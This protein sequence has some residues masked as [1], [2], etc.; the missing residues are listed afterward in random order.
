MMKTI[1][2]ILF[3]FS[4]LNLAGCSVE[5][6]ENT[7]QSQSME[8]P[9]I[10]AVDHNCHHQDNNSQH[11]SGDHCHGHCHCPFL[12]TETSS[13]SVELIVTTQGINTETLYT[14]PYPNNLLRPPII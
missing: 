9:T 4:I 6:E 1:V 12:M 10:S 14:D 2:S 7:V 13:V 3:I 5:S 11:D 8:G